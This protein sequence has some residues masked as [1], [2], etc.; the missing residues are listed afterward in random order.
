MK[1]FCVLIK[2]FSQV[3]SFTDKQAVEFYNQLSDKPRG[4]SMKQKW[5]R[6]QEI[7]LQKEA[8]AAAKAAAEAAA[9]AARAA[10]EEE[11]RKYSSEKTVEQETLIRKIA[12]LVKWLLQSGVL[13]ITKHGVAEIVGCPIPTLE[14]VIVYLNQDAFRLAHTIEELKEISSELEA[15]VR[16]VKLTNPDRKVQDERANVK[17]AQQNSDVLKKQHEEAAR[18][19]KEAQRVLGEAEKEQRVLEEAREDQNH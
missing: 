19:V 14:F 10:K 2:V 15:V 12:S 5:I 9:E 17:A 11:I 4:Q 13:D 16:G 3:M 1:F 8:E 18:K 6:G 7:F